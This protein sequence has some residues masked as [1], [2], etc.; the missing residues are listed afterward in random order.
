MMKKGFT[1][2]LALLL[3]LS[4]GC[5]RR[6]TGE[7]T[8]PELEAARDQALAV[9]EQYR[10]VYEGIFSPGSAGLYLTER[11][12]GEILARFESLGYAAVDSAGR[13]PLTNPAQVENFFA[14]GGAL[15]LYEICTDGGFL[16]HSFYRSGG[17]TQVI[18][19]RLFWSDGGPYMLQ[20]T[21]PVISN[22]GQYTL[23]RLE[24]SDGVLSYE[25]DLPG[26]P[27][28]TSHDGHV[29]TLVRLLLG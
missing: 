22:A 23:L 27:P 29:D 6:E 18:R 24:L 11:E 2:L 1:I 5:G 17:E 19:T 10:D 26:N 7:Q 16:C 4:C 14:Q 21:V 3:C 28:G 20:G 15:S 12:T 9:A 13:F 8:P 25:Y